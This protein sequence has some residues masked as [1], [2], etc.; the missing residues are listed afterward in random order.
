M[1]NVA[2]MLSLLSVVLTILAIDSWR[3]HILPWGFEATGYVA[4]FSFLLAGVLA[5]SALAIVIAR[6]CSAADGGLFVVALPASSSLLAL[7]ALV[8]VCPGGC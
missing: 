3:L 8:I 4:A 2:R 5:L 7:V 6:A 1:L